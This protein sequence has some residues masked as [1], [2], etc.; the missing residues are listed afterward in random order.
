MW[1]LEAKKIKLTFYLW[2]KPKSDYS[3]CL[4]KCI[5]FFIKQKEYKVYHQKKIGG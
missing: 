2:Q 4:S 5:L 3:W 1:D